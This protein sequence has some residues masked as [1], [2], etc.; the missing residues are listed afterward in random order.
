MDLSP[1]AAKLRANTACWHRIQLK[2]ELDSLLF[3]TCSI[4][5]S[6]KMATAPKKKQSRNVMT[7]QAISNCLFFYLFIYCHCRCCWGCNIF[8]CTFSCATVRISTVWRKNN[9]NHHHHHYIVVWLTCVHIKLSYTFYCKRRKKNITHTHTAT[10]TVCV[11]AYVQIALVYSMVGC[12]RVCV[13]FSVL[14]AYSSI[15]PIYLFVSL[16]VCVCK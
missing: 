7:T 9:S 15:Y 10:R 12:L 1:F 4:G 5:N 16:A 14:C 11:C 6:Q 13:Y 2:F 3:H 8:Q